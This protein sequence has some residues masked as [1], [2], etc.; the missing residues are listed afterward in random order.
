[1]ANYKEVTI[2]ANPNSQGNF[3][4]NSQ[5]YRGISTVD[6]ESDSVALYDQELIKQDLLNHFNIR[7]GEKIYNPNFGTII[8]DLIYDPLTDQTRDL[9]I[10]DVVAIMDNDP[11]INV[12]NVQVLQRDYGIQ[13][14]CEIEYIKLSV[15]EQMIF[16]FDRENGLST[17]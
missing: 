14:A 16:N 13:I 4:N 3:E 1:M 7:K 10:T 17:L 2:S 5:I 8:W 9:V 11:R 12:S 15:S 6:Q